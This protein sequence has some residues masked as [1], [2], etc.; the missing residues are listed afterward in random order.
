MSKEKK[1]RDIENKERSLKFTNV[2]E[3]N[4]END[5]RD[6]LSIPSNLDHLIIF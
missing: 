3:E 6:M 5:D 1:E 2:V 4:P